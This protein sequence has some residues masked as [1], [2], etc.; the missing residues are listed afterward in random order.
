MHRTGKRGPR[1][2]RS[3]HTKRTGI[4]T[5]YYSIILRIMNQVI[6][7]TLIVFIHVLTMS[8]SFSSRLLNSST[9]V[10]YVNNESINLKFCLKNYIQ[11]FFVDNFNP[12]K[13]NILSDNSRLNFN[14]IN[15]LSK[16]LLFHDILTVSYILTFYFK[17]TE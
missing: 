12:H 15:H 17:V 4:S 2:R 1:P 10:V 13:S 9:S 16:S 5:S 14:L 6:L 3:R 7:V 8:I 11:P